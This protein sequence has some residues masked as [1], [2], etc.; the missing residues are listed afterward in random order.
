MGNGRHRIDHDAGASRE[1]G[2]DEDPRKLLRARVP[3][4]PG[5]VDP[6]STPGFPGDKERGVA[7]LAEAEETLQELQ[8]LLY[9]NLQADTA[10]AVLLVLQGMDTGGKDGIVRHVV[11]AVSP[12]GVHV[13]AFKA[14]TKE[15]QAHDF[16]WRVRNE[17]P[18]AGMI[19]VFNRSHYE[20]VLIQRVRKMAEPDEIERRYGKIVEFERD[21]VASGTR[22][23]KVMLHIS[24]D[25]Q[26]ARLTERLEDP[27][28]YWK[29]NP[30][31]VDERML[32]DDYQEAYRIAIDRTSTDDAPWYVVP[33]NRKWYARLAVQQLLIS[34]LS[35]LHLDWPDA[36]F[37]IEK[38]KKRLADS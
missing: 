19:G 11:G 20:D 2:W 4:V 21:V 15:E 27:T 18:E 14:P 16:L 38:E 3:F 7:A 34:V 36:A 23:I 5:D 8:N 29:Y 24:R 32:W 9:A 13:S 6:S 35:D 17:L 1:K 12:A 28:K 31:D 25:E 33:A 37:D 22:L 10:P 30:A 26:K